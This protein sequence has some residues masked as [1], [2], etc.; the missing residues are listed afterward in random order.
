M[1]RKRDKLAGGDNLVDES[2]TQSL[3]QALQHLYEP[4][5]LR[6]SPLFGLLGLDDQHN[7]SDL[8]RMLVDAIE[9]LKPRAGV[10]SQS[11]AQRTYYTL[12]HRYVAQF[13]QTE[14]AANLGL[15]VRH[16]RRQENIALRVLADYLQTHHLQIMGPEDDDKLLDTDAEEDQ[17]ST[18]TASRK[19]ELEWL[20]RSL[21]STPTDLVQM[22]HRVLETVGPLAETSHVRIECTIPSGLPRLAVQLVTMRQSLISAFAAAIR[23][24]PDGKIVIK[25]ELQ[26]RQ[27]SILI[28]P[29]AP[30]PPPSPTPNNH[31]EGLQMARQLAELSGGTLESTPGG[32]PECPFQIK[33]I[34]P[35]AEERAVL[36]VDDNAD[37]LQLFRRYLTGSSYLFVGTSDPQQALSLAQDLKPQSIV[38]DVML[39]GIDGWELLGQLRAHPEIGN[40]PVIICTIL[41]QER[42]AL[43]LGAAGFLRKPFTRKA[44][45]SALDLQ[46]GAAA[47]GSL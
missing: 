23:S 6:R 17:S 9:S 40:T 36:V 16:L 20:E 37:T 19:Q 24:V 21:P 34:L 39:P 32:T 41:P 35:T 42:L 2:F 3:R 25:A 29:I 47:P 4:A 8:R 12:Y 44:L 11:R 14:V 31:I 30:K 10:S 26:P 22:I 27:V 7:P 15:S 28:C 38:L 5:E 43:T 33:L 18:K 45:L 46:S 13:S 1:G